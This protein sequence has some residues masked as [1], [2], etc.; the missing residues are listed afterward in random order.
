MKN[1]QHRPKSANHF[2]NNFKFNNNNNNNNNINP[3]SK[4]TKIFS[5]NNS[6][7]QKTNKITFQL[8]SNQYIEVTPNFWLPVDLTAIFKEFQGV[9][10][11]E[12]KSW[13]FPF[14]NY[15]N[16]YNTLLKYDNNYSLI[17]EP[18]PLFTI[19]F[20]INSEDLTIL[21][22]HNRQV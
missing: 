21:N 5:K 17:L 14:R 10:I 2:E 18:I 16:L 22:F 19:D 9:Y 12:N 1:S 8:I 20:I 15:K 11:R 7:K 13:K 4:A 6:F 3:S